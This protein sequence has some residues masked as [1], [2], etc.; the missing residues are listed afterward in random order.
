MRWFEFDRALFIRLLAALE[1]PWNVK[2]P[3]AEKIALRR[4][5]EP[6]PD[7]AELEHG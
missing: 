7:V 4:L 5:H 2:V 3:S 6:A 1:L